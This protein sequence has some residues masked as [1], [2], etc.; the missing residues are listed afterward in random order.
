MANYRELIRQAFAAEGID[1][2]KAVEVFGHEGL[3]S[4]TWQS[5]VTKNGVRE[6]SYGPLQFLVGGGNTGFPRGM[7]NDYMDATGNDPRVQSDE[8]VAAMA[9]F[10]AARAK[11][12]GWAD[13]YGARDN[14]IG[15]WE[16]IGKGAGDRQQMSKPLTLTSPPPMSIL[17]P[18]IDPTPAVSPATATGI[19]TGMMP[20]VGG[21]AGSET[22]GGLA[23]AGLPGAATTPG[24]GFLN[25]LSGM[26]TAFGKSR[27]GQR[28]SGQ[29]QPANIDAHSGEAAAAQ[30]MAELIAKRKAMMPGLTMGT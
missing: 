3:G 19:G 1:P 18:E 8:N 24:M 7:G 10:A 13:W 11:Q 27:T 12:N 26:A 29:L 2:D 16:G 17:H 9:K 30:L 28:G 14:G 22:L 20:D 15:R 5:R 4:K 21:G 23:T 25:A 6:P